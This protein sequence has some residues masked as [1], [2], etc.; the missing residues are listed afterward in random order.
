[1]VNNVEKVIYTKVCMCGKPVEFECDN[2]NTNNIL[3]QESD[4]GEELDSFI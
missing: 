3:S 1:M 2:L 4:I